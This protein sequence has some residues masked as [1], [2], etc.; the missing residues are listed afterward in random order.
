MVK[1]GRGGDGSFVCGGWMQ[2]TGVECNQTPRGKT[3]RRWEGGAMPCHGPDRPSAPLFNHA[4]GED[5][6]RDSKVKVSKAH[7]RRRKR[8]GG[9]VRHMYPGLVRPQK[10]TKW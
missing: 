5:L 10:R 7:N 2:R 1:I 4:L 6:R 8:L 9:R 3:Q